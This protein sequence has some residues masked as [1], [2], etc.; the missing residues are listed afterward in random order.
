MQLLQAIDS[1]REF[2]R[3]G[4]LKARF[5]KFEKGRL[6]EIGESNFQV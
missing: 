6:S 3:V 1:S 5:S 4:K 2:A